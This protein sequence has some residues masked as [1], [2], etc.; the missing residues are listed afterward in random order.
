MARETL[1]V[2]H[3]A[4]TCPVHIEPG[5]I[6]TIGTSAASFGLEGQVIVATNHT[7]QALYGDPLVTSLPSARLSVIPDGE[8]YKTLEIVH[9]LY[10]DWLALGADRHTTIVALGGGVIGDT[11]GFA[12]ATYMRGL[13]F[14]QVPTT[15]LAMVDSSVG[16][17]VGVDLPQGK[18]LVGAFK[19]PDCVLID[20][21]TLRTLSP[22]QL[23][24]GL[25]EVI[26]HGLLADPLLLNPAMYTSDKWPELIRRAVQ[27]KI[28]IVQQDPYEAGVRAYLNLGHTFAHAV[29]RV[30]EY[31]WPH[32]EAVAVGLRAAIML[33]I[34]LGYCSPEVL[35][36]V[37]IILA[38]AGLPVSY[39]GLS[40]TAIYE[41]MSTDKKWQ[42]GRNRFV[43]LRAVAE[44]ILI[45]DVP[46]SQILSVLERL[47]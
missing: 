2:Q 47:C 36:T 32:G 28:D 8:Q 44:P 18:N 6:S 26:K 12:A 3:P 19:Q 25:A 29:E 40:P 21:E 10:D 20:P 22:A 1:N 16:G 45:R 43:G 13:R 33:S 15:L 23:R 14:V 24:C 7:L 46:P 9:Q 17:K 35:N 11:V 30:T 38:E 42:A 39:D 5:L 41:A 37:E 31:A 27:V 4:G 34:E